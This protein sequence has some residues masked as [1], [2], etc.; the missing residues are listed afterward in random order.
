MFSDD[1]WICSAR[2]PD[3]I[4]MCHSSDEAIHGAWRERTKRNVVSANSSESKEDA[5]EHDWN[6]GGEL[7]PRNPTD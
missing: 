6:G 7:D 5:Y 3:R 1:S 4:R 2:S